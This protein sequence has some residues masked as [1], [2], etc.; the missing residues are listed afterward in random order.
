[1]WTL[2]S[3]RRDENQEKQEGATFTDHLQI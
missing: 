1:M 3:R 2:A